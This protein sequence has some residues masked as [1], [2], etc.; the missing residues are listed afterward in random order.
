MLRPIHGGALRTQTGKAKLS[1]FGLARIY[2]DA[3][4]RSIADRL[5]STQSGASSVVGSPYWMAPEVIRGQGSSTKSDVWSLGVTVVE[6]AST[7]PP[8]AHLDTMAALFHIGNGGD[9]GAPADILGWHG[10]A[11]VTQCMTNAR[12][13]RPSC[14]ELMEHPFLLNGNVSQAN[15][16]LSQRLSEQPARLH[17]LPQNTSPFTKKLRPTFATSSKICP[18]SGQCT[19]VVSFSVCPFKKWFKKWAGVLL[20]L[21]NCIPTYYPA[22]FHN[23][24]SLRSP[25]PMGPRGR[26]SP[27]T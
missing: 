5:G 16:T 3:G 27:K 14:D 18:R 11:F 8:L 4:S 12:D 13:R 10:Q 25:G 24:F 15:M 23:D 22:P 21:F 6:M 20:R 1:D 17:P 7:K 2:Y 9:M 26:M 19:A